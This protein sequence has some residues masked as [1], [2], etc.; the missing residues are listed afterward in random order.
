MPPYVLDLDVVWAAASDPFAS[1]L[2]LAALIARATG[3][4]VDLLAEDLH[5]QMVELVQWR[6]P[7]AKA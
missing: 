2:W 3:Q 5:R 7:A 4:P 6:R 1:C